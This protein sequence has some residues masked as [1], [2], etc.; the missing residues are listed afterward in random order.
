MTKQLFGIIY[1]A[2]ISF[3]SFSQTNKDVDFKKHFDK[4]TVDGCF[5]LFD[6]YKNE[7]LRYNPNLCDSSFLPAS[8]F[9]IPNAL[10]ALEEGVVKDTSQIFRWDGKEWQ[11]DN[12]NKDQT[13]RTSMKYS[14]V[15]VYI[16]FAKQIGI[17]KYRKYLHRFA[18]GNNNLTGPADLFWLEGPFSITANQQVGFLR[19]FYHNQLGVS[20]RSIDIVKSIIIIEKTPKYTLSGKTGSAPFGNNEE[21][22]WLVGYLEKAGNRYFYAL[23]FKTND[24]DTKRPARYEITKDILKELKLID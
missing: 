16:N 8:T 11:N 19:K 4:Y 12:W 20:N 18:Y 15:W 3:Y 1:F 10:I 13:L 5:V 6:E 7:F 22:L 23:N 21:V 14:C 9:K 24:P 17:E 2:L